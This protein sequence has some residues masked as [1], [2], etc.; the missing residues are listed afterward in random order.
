MSQN[1]YKIL[2]SLPVPSN[3]PFKP[4]WSSLKKYIV[5]SWF[6][7]SKFGIFIHWGV[8]SVP[9]FGNE[10]Y[11]RYMYMPDRPEHQYHLKNSA[12]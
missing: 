11:P 6:T 8:Y 7:T 4:T 12:Q 10:W 3:G 2:K 5:P 9:A 1:S